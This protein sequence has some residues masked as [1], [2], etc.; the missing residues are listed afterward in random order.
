[1]HSR[2]RPAVCLLV[3]LAKPVAGSP[4]RLRSECNAV[5]LCQLEEV[6]GWAAPCSPAARLHLCAL[7]PPSLLNTLGHALK[8]TCLRHPF[9]ARRLSQTRA[10]PCY[11]LGAPVMLHRTCRWSPFNDK[12]M[13]VTL[14]GWSRQG[15]SVTFP[16][17]LP[18]PWP[19]L[20]T[21]VTLPGWSRHGCSVTFPGCHP[22][23]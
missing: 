6:Q 2:S 7:L 1:M 8:R 16:G 11:W 5:P 4:T 13:Y 19:G 17:C 14:P 18:H 21:L 22:S 12:H 20:P 9:L 3:T 10:S 15:H 23:P